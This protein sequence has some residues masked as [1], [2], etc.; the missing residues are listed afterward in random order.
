LVAPQRRLEV[1]T[2]VKRRGALGL[3]AHGD[4]EDVYTRSRTEMIGLIQIAMGGQV[5][6]ELFFH[7]VSTGPSSDLLYA[8]NV[9]AQMVGACGMSDTLVSLAA[10]QASGFSDTNLVGRVLG[11]GA[12]RSRTEELLQEQK[13]FVRGLLENNQHLVAALRDALV[14]RHE[15]IGHEITDVLETARDGAPGHVID[16]RGAD[17]SALFDRPA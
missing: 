5:A 7:D 16:L 9:A 1:L 14:E 15:L 3:L 17:S 12:G 11:D 2:I 8:T 10:V 13:V 4:R 6:E